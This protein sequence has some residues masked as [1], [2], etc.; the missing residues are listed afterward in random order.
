MISET[1]KAAVW[2]YRAR[3]GKLFRLALEHQI[4]PSTLSATLSGARRVQHDDRLVAL[5]ASLGLEPDDV[6]APDDATL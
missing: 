5:A 4:A 1:F 2:Q 3:G 6:F